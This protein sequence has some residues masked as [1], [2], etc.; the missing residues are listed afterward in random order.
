LVDD[1]LVRLSLLGETEGDGRRRGDRRRLLRWVVGGTR[2]WVSLAMGAFD[3]AT[4]AIGINRNAG[5][6]RGNKV[7]T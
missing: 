6:A 2:E 7:V 5:R 4:S 1:L 3:F